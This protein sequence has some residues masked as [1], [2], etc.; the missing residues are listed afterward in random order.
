MRRVA[1]VVLADGVGQRERDRGAVALD[2]VADARVHDLAQRVERLLR[3]GLVVETDHLEAVAGRGVAP[4][5][6]LGEE[7]ELPQADLADV[8]ERARQRVDVGH[9]HHLLRGGG[10]G[11][12]QR[13]RKGERADVCSHGVLLGR[14]SLWRGARRC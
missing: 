8:G 14:S 9:A 12:E 5:Q 3:T 10:R 7:L 1:L 6:L 11:G 2:H 13:K 4:V